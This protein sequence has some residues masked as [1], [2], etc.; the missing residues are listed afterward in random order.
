MK[1]ANFRHLIVLPFPKKVAKFAGQLAKSSFGIAASLIGTIGLFL[2]LARLVSPSHFGIFS[3]T[4]AVCS[5][6]GT[7]F[8]F[9]F[10]LRFLKETPGLVKLHGGIPARLFYLKLTLFTGLTPIALITLSILKAPLEL[11]FPVWS[12]IALVSMANFLG[13]SIQSI[14]HHGRDSA[15]VFVGNTVGV[16]A[17]CAM[18][19]MGIRDPFLLALSVSATG[20]VHLALAL[21]TWLRFF[22]VVNERFSWSDVVSQ[23]R[24]SI[25]Y[26]LDA[27]T[28]RSFNF[29]DI[30]ILSLF[31][32]SAQVGLYEAGRKLVQGAF[33]F[34]QAVNQV[35]LPRL[36]DAAACPKMWTK[37]ALLIVISMCSVGLACGCLIYVLRET[38]VLTIFG[39]QY[40]PATPLISI[41]GIMVCFRFLASSIGLL[42]TSL[43]LQ[44][45]RAIANSISLV[46]FVV[47]SMPM[48]YQFGAPGMAWSHVIA[49][50]IL[51]V[52]FVVCFANRGVLLK[53]WSIF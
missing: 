12:G 9:G 27:V 25:A 3:L 45:Q 24:A 1:M 20:T 11:F 15:N 29:V 31:V 16:F 17:L 40:K 30:V 26:T 13:A 47:A 37:W 6:F 35:V 8:D 34:V 46:C 39:E 50:S 2:I 19:A 4:Y 10:R 21:W 38:L 7:I 5:I 53:K 52:G 51:F 48:S 23:M 32:S 33:T 22:K 36:T 49:T 41:F 14:G 42:L 28:Q 44:K 18:A 43:G